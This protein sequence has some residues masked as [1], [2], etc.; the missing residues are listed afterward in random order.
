MSRKKWFSYWYVLVFI[1]KFYKVRYLYRKIMTF[2]REVVINFNPGIET[3]TWLQLL[4]KKNGF[5]LFFAINKQKNIHTTL[6]H[7][8]IAFIVP[9][10]KGI[11]SHYTRDDRCFNFTAFTQREMS[12]HHQWYLCLLHWMIQSLIHLIYPRFVDSHP[13]FHRTQHQ[14]HKLLR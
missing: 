5:H 4:P 1:K 10:P 13:D 9:R 11:R 2:F 7:T 8:H 14:S 12:C 3:Q 6:P